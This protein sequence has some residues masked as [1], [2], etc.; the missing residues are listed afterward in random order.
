ML[1]YRVNSCFT[2]TCSLLS[3]SHPSWPGSW[4]G[5]SDQTFVPVKAKKRIK[6][7]K[8]QTETFEFED[9]FKIS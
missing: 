3:S 6:T 9:Q 4:F 8:K 5:S 2:G 7:G 1:F